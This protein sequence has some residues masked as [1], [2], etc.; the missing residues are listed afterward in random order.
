MDIR[1]SWPGKHRTNP[2]IFT[3]SFAKAKTRLQNRICIWLDRFTNVSRT[4]VYWYFANQGAAQFEKYI[5]AVNM[6]LRLK[7]N[8]HSVSNLN[9]L[10]SHVLRLLKLERNAWFDRNQLVDT[11]L[12]V[13]DLIFRVAGLW[14]VQAAGGHH[15][16]R[17]LLQA[18]S[19]QQLFT[20][21]HERY[22]LICPSR[23]K[24]ARLP[25]RRE[26]RIYPLIP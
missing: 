26:G 13:K 19:G 8:T 23:L 10:F 18:V 1:N 4:K 7:S 12:A 11:G 2:A 15:H 20:A 6:S 17:D 25:W 14:H 16:Q 5:S 22:I 24:E 9:E 3:Q 21:V